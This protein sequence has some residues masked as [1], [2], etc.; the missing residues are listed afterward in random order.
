MNDINHERGILRRQI[1]DDVINHLRSHCRDGQL[2][3]DQVFSPR[4]VVGQSLPSNRS[5][6]QVKGRGAFP[7]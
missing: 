4:W 7:S 2:T 5:V 6:R 1:K 3:I